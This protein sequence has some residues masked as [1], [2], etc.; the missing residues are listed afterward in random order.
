MTSPAKLL[1]D[2]F[3]GFEKYIFIYIDIL[4]ETGTISKDVRTGR[5]AIERGGELVFIDGSHFHCEIVLR[6]ERDLP[7]EDEPPGRFRLIDFPDLFCI[8]Y[9]DTYRNRFG[10]EP[11]RFDYHP[12][13][14]GSG[15]LWREP[16][17]HVQVYKQDIP[18]FPTR[19]TTL[20]DVLQVIE[21]NYFWEARQQ[22]LAKL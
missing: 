22:R 12:E 11:F 13:A 5:F 10:G 15:D 21:A 1:R 18:R 7:P 17:Y 8:K 20:A 2:A 19:A 14:R 3:D 6:H 16:L 4:R 9:S